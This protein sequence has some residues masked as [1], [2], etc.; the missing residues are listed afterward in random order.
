LVTVMTVKLSGLPRVPSTVEMYMIAPA[1][2][3]IARSTIEPAA[4]GAAGGRSHSTQPRKLA[5]RPVTPCG[6]CCISYR[7]A[8]GVTPRGSVTVIP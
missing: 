8:S 6:S 2:P 5:S 7:N 4:R 3:V 1:S